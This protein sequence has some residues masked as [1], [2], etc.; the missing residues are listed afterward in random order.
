M[1]RRPL[2]AIGPHRRASERQIQGPK[3]ADL[4]QGEKNPD[5]VSVFPPRS[6]SSPT[7]QIINRS[8]GAATD[9]HACTSTAEMCVATSLSLARE[10]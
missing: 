1:D 10:L 5:I 2:K 7:V 9:W 4:Q 8:G 6:G 3:R